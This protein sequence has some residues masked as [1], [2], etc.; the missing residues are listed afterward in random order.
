MAQTEWSGRANVID[1]DSLYVGR[2]EVRL[3]GIDSPDHGQRCEQAGGGSWACDEAA[4]ELLKRLAQDRT[5]AC[6]PEGL[7]RN[8]RVIAMCWADGI[9]L[10]EKLVTKG[11]SWA[12]RDHSTEYAAAEV[13]AQAEERGIW[14]N[15]ARPAPPWEFR[16]E[17]SEGGPTGD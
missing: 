6:E 9:D 12:N 17:Q 2:A 5:V 1:G 13:T 4:K 16:A 8:D 7:D 15:G 10:G 11:L 14:E 3:Y